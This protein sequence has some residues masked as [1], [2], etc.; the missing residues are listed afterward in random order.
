M[1]W[2]RKKARKEDLDRELSSDLELEAEEQRESGLSPEQAQYAARRA[3][4]NIVL[5]KE[6]VRPMWG[7]TRWDILIQDLRYAFRTLRKSPGFA[8]TA[9]LTLA[10]GIG[11]STAVFTVVD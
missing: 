10:L 4:G 7:W 5:T 1:K 11:A 9:I 6:E 3:F 8:A 2:R